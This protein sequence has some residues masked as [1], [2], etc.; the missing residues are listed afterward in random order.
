MTS[1][2]TERYTVLSIC[3]TVLRLWMWK[4]MM[5]THK[6]ICNFEAVRDYYQMLL[7]LFVQVW[8][9][10]VCEIL[11][12]NAKRWL[13]KWQA[14]LGATLFCHTLYNINTSQIYVR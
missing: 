1:P 4:S 2:T 7:V 14:T 6:K 9:S 5:L 13:K 10:N 8:K 12:Q 11:C 3:I